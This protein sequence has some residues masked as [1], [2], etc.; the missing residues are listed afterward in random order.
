MVGA[1]V[2]SVILRDRE[3]MEGGETRKV[4]SEIGRVERKKGQ[5]GT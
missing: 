1:K 5:G 4:G 2:G 3:G